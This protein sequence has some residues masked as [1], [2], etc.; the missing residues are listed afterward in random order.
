MANPLIYNN[1]LL[2]NTQTNMIIQYP[3]EPHIV[4]NNNYKSLENSMVIE[5]GNIALNQELQAPAQVKNNLFSEQI[6]AP[7]FNKK[8]NI[9]SPTLSNFTP[10]TISVNHNLG[11]ANTK[12]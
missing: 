2:E 3:S 9:V 12:C 7:S 8:L 5:N 11:N 6:L 10:I 1:N 4:N